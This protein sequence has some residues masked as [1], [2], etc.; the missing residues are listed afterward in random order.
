[1]GITVV[2]SAGNDGVN[3]SLYSPAHTPEAITVGAYGSDRKVSSFS[4]TGSVVDLYAPG[5]NVS[6]VAAGPYARFVYRE[7][8]TSIAAPH[9]AG[10]AALVLAKYP[11]YTPAQVRNTLVYRGTWLSGGVRALNVKDLGN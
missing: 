2:V 8:G 6:V 7:S 5:D 9:V 4:N 1:M 11:N 10:A 3:A